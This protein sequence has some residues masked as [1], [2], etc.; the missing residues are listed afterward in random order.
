[1][2]TYVEESKI[3]CINEQVLELGIEGL[4]ESSEFETSRRM[5]PDKSEV[6][7]EVK[8]LEDMLIVPVIK[9]LH[10]SCLLKEL[11]KEKREIIEGHT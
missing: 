6:C 2:K 4:F 3:S 5:A 1:M 8:A 10:M 9:A 7:E 11:I